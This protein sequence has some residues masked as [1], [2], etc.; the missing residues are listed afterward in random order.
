MYWENN[1]VNWKTYFKQIPV[2]VQ[3]TKKVKYDVTWT[4]PDPSIDH[5]GRT[6]TDSKNIVVSLDLKP[7]MAVHTYLHEVL[8]AISEEYVV[9]L[10]EKQVLA[11]EKALYF[12]LKPGNLFKEGKK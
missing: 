3:L 6:H 1:V 11:L 9:N 12:V 2:S 4:R 8:H 10:T 5:M 7:R